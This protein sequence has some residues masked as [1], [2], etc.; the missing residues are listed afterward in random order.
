MVLSIRLHQRLT[1][2]GKLEANHRWVPQDG[3]PNIQVVSHPGLCVT[4][5]LLHRHFLT[6]CTDPVAAAAISGTTFP[7][8][9]EATL[10]T[11]PDGKS[12]PLAI[13]SHGV[14][15]SRLMYSAFCGELASQGYIVASL[16]HRDGT[17]PSSKLTT[18]D[19]ATKIVDWVD[20]KDLQYELPYLLSDRYMNTS[21]Q[22]ARPQRPTYRRHDTPA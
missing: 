1:V 6:M 2:T 15:C 17:S 13:F 3:E 20:W 5:I 8:D 12:W 21:L 4:L 9:T 19:G 7:A 16:E 14:G 22:L 11:P 18:V 10:L